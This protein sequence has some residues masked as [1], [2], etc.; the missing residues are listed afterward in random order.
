MSTPSAL[1]KVMIDAA[2]KAARGLTRDFGELAELQ[3]SRKG[4]ADYVSAADMKAEQVLFDVARYQVRNM[5]MSNP[6][7]IAPVVYGGKVRAVAVTEPNDG[8]VGLIVPKD[9]PHVA[10][11]GLG[12]NT[13]VLEYQ[14]VVHRLR[15]SA[16]P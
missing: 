10:T 6:G 1:L 9:S 11:L 12:A 14:P 8:N 2:R 4:P 16:S 13:V 5:L 3:V 7:A 15:L